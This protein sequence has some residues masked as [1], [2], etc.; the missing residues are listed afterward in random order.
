MFY[1]EDY[2]TLILGIFFS[3]IGFLVFATR[4]RLAQTEARLIAAEMESER[5]ERLVTLT[6]LKLLQAQIEPHFLFNTLS[7]I[8]GLIHKRPDDAEKTLVNLTRLLRSS[9]SRTRKTE[10][11]VAEEIDIA[12]AYLEIHAIRMSDRLQY[13]ITVDP[14]VSNAPLPPLLIQPLV[15][16][17]ITHGID[18]LEQGGIINIDAQRDGTPVAPHA[19]PRHLGP[20]RDRPAQRPH[21]EPIG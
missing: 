1:T 10:T 2:A 19:V 16:N 6:E 4:T 21:F 15:E 9:L 11:T 20:L 3:V 5:Q 13:R 8:A 18:Q 14:T 7:N 12:R 17:A